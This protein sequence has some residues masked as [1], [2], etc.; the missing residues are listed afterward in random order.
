MERVVSVFSGDDLLL[1]TAAA[2]SLRARVEAVLSGEDVAV[3]DF[4]QVNGVSTEFA[5]E[6]LAPLFDR[7]GASMPDRVLLDH[8]SAS[9]LNDL[10]NVAETHRPVPTEHRPSIRRGRHAA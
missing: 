8:C 2:S 4:S 6:L 3:L 5:D 9:V 7:L 10:K 1:D